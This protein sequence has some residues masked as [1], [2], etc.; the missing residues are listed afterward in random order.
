MLRRVGHGIALLGLVVFEVPLI[1]LSLVALLQASGLGIIP[2]FPLT[3]GTVRRFATLHRQLCG[4]WCDVLIELPYQPPP[5]PPQRSPDGWYRAGRTLYRTPRFPAWRARFGW[6]L[7]DPATWRDFAWLALDPFVKLGLAVGFVVV[8]GR[9]LRLYGRWAAVLLSPNAARRL[10]GEVQRLV[11]VRG[12]AADT[13]AAELRRI[14]RDLHD[15]AQARLVA[16]GMAVA[17]AESLIDTQPA[18]AKAMLERAREGSAEALAELRRVVRGINPPVLVERG[19]PDALRAL[20]LDSPLRVTVDPGPARSLP[21]PVEAAVY[22]IVSELL[23]NAAKHARADTASVEVTHAEG[24][25]R[26]RV[27]DDGVG[28]ADPARGSGLAG[29]ERRLAAFDGTITV[30]SPAGGPTAVTLTI[31]D[32]QPPPQGDA[33]AREPAWETLVVV[34]GWTLGWLP[35]FPQGLVPALLKLTGSEDPSWFLP[36]HLPAPWQWPAIASMIALGCAMYFLAI[37]LPIRR[38]RKTRR[39]RQRN[40]NGNGDAP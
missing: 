22:F 38:A 3:V 36:L 13:Q 30:D 5:P 7:Q 31:P 37:W 12:L 26:V 1:V 23:G 20:A 28:G 4:Q 33:L 8:P 11:A 9:A 27:V 19:L 18:N 15:G 39:G 29:I 17:A 35:L 32:A 10:A 14:E 21:A 24:R 34:A 2:L 25:L 6:L 16:L 40:G